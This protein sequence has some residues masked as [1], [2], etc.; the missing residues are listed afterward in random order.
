MIKHGSITHSTR[1]TST[2]RTRLKRLTGRSQAIYRR[3]PNTGFLY[4]ILEVTRQTPHFFVSGKGV[5]AGYSLE[6]GCANPASKKPDKEG[7]RNHFENAQPGR[8]DTHSHAPHDR[9]T[10]TDRVHRQTNRILPSGERLRV[11]GQKRDD[12]SQRA[13]QGHV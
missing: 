3:R 7:A 8:R 6:M 11:A 10:F 9:E 5:C 13:G 2:T 12:I 4:E 1:C